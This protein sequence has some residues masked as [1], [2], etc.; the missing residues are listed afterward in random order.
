MDLCLSVSSRSRHVVHFPARLPVARGVRRKRAESEAGGTAR[1][2][3]NHRDLSLIL[4]SH[5]KGADQG[6]VREIR[7]IRVRVRFLDLLPSNV[8]L[9]PISADPTRR[10]MSSAIIGR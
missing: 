6:A 9:T 3:L 1:L 8:T 2:T 7:E 4:V 10:S 5:S